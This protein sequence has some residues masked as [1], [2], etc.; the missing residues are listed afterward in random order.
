M[1]YE[2][3]FFETIQKEIGGKIPCSINIDLFPKEIN[4][5]LFIDYIDKK[6]SLNNLIFFH[7]NVSYYLDQKSKSSDESYYYKL[8][9]ILYLS[10]Y[11]IND[12]DRVKITDI[13]VLSSNQNIEDLVEFE[14]YIKNFDEKSFLRETKIDKLDKIK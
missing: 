13:K 4:Y 2:E 10:I 6:Y 1:K 7:K 12:K 9:N 11:I 5:E 3:L 8:G 14:N